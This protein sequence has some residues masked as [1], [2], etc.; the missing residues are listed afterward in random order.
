MSMIKRRVL[1]EEV[2]EIIARMIYSSELEPGQWID[3][4]Q[5][6]ADL[7]ISRTPLREALK[8]LASDGLVELITRRGAYVKTISPDELDE[9]FPIVALL[10]GFCAQLAAENITSE[11]LVKLKHIHSNL[12]R[13]A[14]AKDI[15]LYYEENILFHDALKDISQNSRLQRLTLDLSRVIRLARQQQLKLGARLQQSLQEHR[16][17]LSAIE[18]KDGESANQAMS[19]HIDNQY[20]ALK[21]QLVGAD[22][23]EMD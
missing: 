23:N 16:D 4:M 12:E 15:V 1:Y 9:L 6:C 14:A 5:L 18:A 22:K 17:I 19:L 7:G 20:A 10:E 3:E 2:A 21:N 11:E 8:V 13:H